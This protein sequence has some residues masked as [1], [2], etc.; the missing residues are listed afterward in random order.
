MSGEVFK[1]CYSICRDVSNIYLF[2]FVL[3]TQPDC[4]ASFYDHVSTVS[5]IA[6]KY[7]N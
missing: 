2:A 7:C 5:K 4:F 1:K 3:I 6:V